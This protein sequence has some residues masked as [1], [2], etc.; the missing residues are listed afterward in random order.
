MWDMQ[1]VTVVEDMVAGM[2]DMTGTEDPITGVETV[3][4]DVRKKGK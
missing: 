3:M 4:D 1:D 2:E